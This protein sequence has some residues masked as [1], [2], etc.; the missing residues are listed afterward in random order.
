MKEWFSTNYLKLNEDKTK[1]VLFLKL[2]V[3][4]KFKL[5]K[6]CFT[7]ATKRGEIKQNDWTSI[8]EVKAKVFDLTP[9]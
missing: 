1:L 6:N 7:I 2:S 9:N 4:K 3:F 8:S 5:S